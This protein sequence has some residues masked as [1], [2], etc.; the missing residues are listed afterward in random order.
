MKKVGQDR[1]RKE[2]RRNWR[3]GTGLLRKQKLLRKEKKL[4]L[5]NI[6]T[7]VDFAKVIKSICF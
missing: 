4:N 6:G 1:D 3:R 2:C 7:F 5:Q